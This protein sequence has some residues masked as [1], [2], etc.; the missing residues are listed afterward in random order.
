[1]PPSVAD[2]FVMVKPRDRWPNPRKLKAD[3][4]A[5]VEAEMKK[6]PGNNYEFTQPIQ[7]RTNELISG[8]RADVAIN[9]Y[10][11][12]LDTLLEV[13]QKIEAAARKVPGAADVRLEQ[14]AGLPMLSVLPDRDALARYGLNP[15]DVQRSGGRPSVVRGGGPAV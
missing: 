14:A 5:E 1:M 10:G 4:V 9:L 12:D 8:V 7:M 11:D 6:I 15:A 13:G 2:T 3:L